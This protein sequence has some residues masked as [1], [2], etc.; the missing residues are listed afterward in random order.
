MNR[1][2][3]EPRLAVADVAAELRSYPDVAPFA[4]AQMDVTCRHGCHSYVARQL[5]FRQGRIL[6]VDPRTG[7]FGIALWKSGEGVEARQ[8]PFPR[9]AVIMFLRAIDSINDD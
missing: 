8:Y 5:A 6:F 2:A 3:R 1:M 7:Q 9:A 4:T